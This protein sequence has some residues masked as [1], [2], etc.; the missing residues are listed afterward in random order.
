MKMKIAYNQL[1][2]IYVNVFNLKVFLYN[3]DKKTQTISDHKT[4]RAA[5]I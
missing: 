2:I 3:S 1:K 4:G 5:D